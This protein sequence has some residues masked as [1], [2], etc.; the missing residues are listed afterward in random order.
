MTDRVAIALIEGLAPWATSTPT[1]NSWIVANR[2]PPT[3]CRPAKPSLRM[4]ALP[5]V[6]LPPMVKP[7]RSTFTFG[8]PMTRPSPGQP[9]RSDRRVTFRVTVAPHCS[10]GAVAPAPA[11]A[12]TVPRTA[13]VPATTVKS[14]AL[15]RMIRLLPRAG[16]YSARSQ[17]RAVFR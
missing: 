15:V 7:S 2:P 4:P 13:V 12:P 10:G 16:P 8:A 9:T 14:T 1:S 6:L 3:T 11:L 17:G 5:G